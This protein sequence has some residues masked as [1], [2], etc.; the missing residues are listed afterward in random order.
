MRKHLLWIATAPLLMGAQI[1]KFPLDEQTTQELSYYEGYSQWKG[2]KTRSHYEINFE[3]MLA[4]MKDAE[5]NKPLPLDLEKRCQKR[6]EELTT[7]VWDY[8]CQTNLES[9][10]SYLA[11]IAT[12]PIIKELK[13]GKLFYEVLR[14]GSISSKAKPKFQYSVHGLDKGE[15]DELYT[16]KEPLPVDL[17]AAVEGFFLGTKGMKIGEKRKIY[18]H[19][20]L[21]YGE[22]GTLTNVP[23]QCLLVFEVER[24]E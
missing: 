17:D 16:S 23:P 8:Y 15:L 22:Y 3:Q 21:A 10:N 4:G 1:G 6:V 14:A 19:P 7:D 12:Q 5:A 18:V 11:K 2:A 24:W 13:K 20:D 9:A